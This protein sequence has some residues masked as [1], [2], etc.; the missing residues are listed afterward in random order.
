MTTS[1][2]FT[3]IRF[4]PDDIAGVPLAGAILAFFQAGT[5]TPITVYQDA[6]LVTPFGSSVTADGQGAFAPIYLA[7]AFVKTTLTTSGGTLVQTVDNITVGIGDSTLILKQSAVPAPTAE[8]DIQW[9][10]N[11]DRIAVGNGGGTSTFSNDVTNAATYLGAAS[12]ATAAQFMNNTASKVIGPNTVWN[13]GIEVALTDA[14]TIAVDM[15]TFINGSVTLAGNRTLGTPTNAKPGQSGRVR[16]LQDGSGSRTLAYA[17]N[18]KF[19][20]AAAPVL[21]T[22]AGATDLLYYDVITSSIIY[23]NLVKAVA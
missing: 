17:A 13:A 12:I 22:T 6:G 16:I 5:T 21:T 11:D 14:A 15:N 1:P 7:A 23:A 9:D 2:I 8:G 4:Q 18:W 3:S 19:A 20:S 10:T